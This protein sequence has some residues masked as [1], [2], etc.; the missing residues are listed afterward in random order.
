MLGLVNVR[1]FRI[2]SVINPESITEF[3]GHRLPL[4]RDSFILDDDHNPVSDLPADFVAQWYLCAQAN[5]LDLDTKVENPDDLCRRGHDLRFTGKGQTNDLLRRLANWGGG[6]LKLRTK[7]EL[8]AWIDSEIRSL[9]GFEQFASEDSKW[10][11]DHDKWAFWWA[12]SHLESN[13]SFRGVDRSQPSTYHEDKQNDAI[14][15]LIVCVR[16]AAELFGDVFG[17]INQ[18]INVVRSIGQQLFGEACSKGTFYKYR[19]VWEHLFP[20]NRNSNL[21][22]EDNIFSF[23]EGREQL[24]QASPITA[25]ALHNL[26]K[27]EVVYQRI[28]QGF[29]VVHNLS[30]QL[31]E[32][33][34]K[35]KQLNQAIPST[36]TL[37]TSTCRVQPTCNDI[38]LQLTPQSLNESASELVGNVK[39]AVA[40]IREI[41]LNPLQQAERSTAITRPD[42][43]DLSQ[44][45]EIFITREEFEST[46]LKHWIL[47]RLHRGKRSRITRDQIANNRIWNHLCRIPGVVTNL[48]E[49]GQV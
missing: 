21:S 16:E 47:G 1:Y 27:A 45:D 44:V 9:P 28:N 48:E 19:Q 3:N 8:A 15:R 39:R 4:Q 12:K 24:A 41:V 30:E 40:S 22:G 49:R 17:S 46:R 10:K 2:A 20:G 6:I 29:E 38:A 43:H 5:D 36:V 31:S 25:E 14:A 37:E 18:L 32:D 7:P 34:A 26:T 13:W 11:L 33:S 42:F 35:H 23:E